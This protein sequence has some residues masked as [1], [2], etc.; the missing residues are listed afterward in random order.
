[1]SERKTKF[2]AYF[3]VALILVASFIMTISQ[4]DEKPK[5]FVVAFC[6]IPEETVLGMLKDLGNVNG[7]QLTLILNDN[8][9]EAIIGLQKNLEIWVKALDKYELSVQIVY[10]FYNETY[11]FVS[12]RL[13]IYYISSFSE[14]F[15]EH[16]Y[17]NVTAVLNEHSNVKLFLGF[18]EP[19]FHFQKQDFPTIVERE[20]ETWKKHSN[21]PFT[22]EFPMPYEFWADC[23]KQPKNPNMT[24]DYVPYWK[25]SDYIGVN[26]WPYARPPVNGYTFT[27]EDKKR[28][29]GA[30]NALVTY[31]RSL[32]KPV[33]IAEFPSWDTEDLHDVAMRFGRDPNILQVYQLW[34]WAEEQTDFDGWIY[35]LYNV[36]RNT[37]NF[38]RVNQTWQ[39]LEE[40]LPFRNQD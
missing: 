18:N 11:G 39:V 6:T 15:C 27:V 37:L 1:M 4:T 25:Y 13:A 16:L 28:V 7:V 14:E 36:N 10:N 32:R 40:N 3:I 33:C 17:G 5:V 35:G 38:S 26:L 30:V 9:S 24:T 2:A 20:Y 29:E 8:S 34:Y 21:I 23:F 31:S 19:Q 12:N 22:T